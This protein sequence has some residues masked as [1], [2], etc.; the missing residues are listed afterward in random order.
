MTARKLQTEIDR[1]LKKVSE[2]VETFEEIFDK[3]TSTPN[4]N[5]KDK[6]E[7]DLK[8]EIKKLQRHRDQIKTWAASNEIKDKRALLENR[9]LIEQQMEK[10]K[11]CEKEMKTKTYSKE[12]LL[13][14]AE[15]DPREKEKQEMGEWISS[16]VDELARQMETTEAEVETLRGGSKKGKKDNAKAQRA[17]E[18]QE[19]IER[20][21]WHIGRLELILRLLENDQISTEQVAD[22]Q[23]N[24]K[25][26]VE[27][28]QEPDFEE[29]ELIYEELNLE[30]EEANYGLAASGIVNGHD[31]ESEDEV[32][33]STKNQKKEEEP[34]G[35]T[36]TTTSPTT[37]RS[38]LSKIQTSPVVPRKPALS[39][40]DA[41]SPS[42]A[43]SSITSP[44]YAKA[45]ASSITRGAPLT[46][47]A[48][49][50]A[51]SPP[52][53]YAKVAAAAA[54]AS[55]STPNEATPGL[56]SGSNS[57]AVANDSKGAK[58]I[59]GKPDTMTP[60]V[61]GVMSMKL[62]ED[63]TS[64]EVFPQS[65]QDTTKQSPENAS[66]QTAPDNTVA[67]GKLD[68]DADVD[69][70]DI[71]TALTNEDG[72]YLFPPAIRDLVSS[73]ESVREKVVTV[74]DDTVYAHQMLD[75]SFSNLPDATDSERPKRYT[76]RNP[77]PVPSYYPQQP[78]G[79][80]D[81]PAFYERFDV[82]VLF[83]IFYFQQGT[84]QQYLAARE[85]KRQSWRF[86][87][88]Y[89]TWFQRHEE[90]KLITDEYEQGTYIYFD[91][92]GAWCQRKKTEF[93]FEYRYLE[94]A[95]V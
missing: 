12:G 29:D 74:K 92:E 78:M 10:F 47:A 41:D 21:K 52:T 75:A 36:S 25:Y 19:R 2:G 88:K 45:A 70:I 34:S 89:L 38:N 22:I 18:L 63:K 46:P 68:E 53:G 56:V 95:D 39:S 84:Y 17:T 61:A 33:L 30:E 9:K 51:A 76:P 69:I 66:A 77:Y 27:Q 8:K 83:F 87:K 14:Q 59:I 11:A 5:Q 37:S 23:E 82:D 44:V 3:L 67:D 35:T 42:A 6:L 62:G 58:S 49:I 65:M 31:D 94:D 48:K 13:R 93:R 79:F 64:N 26:Y 40:A 16:M 57:D 60:L 32:P 1:L 90:P 85:L 80:L 43:K 54:A 24:V 20:Y 4:P 55:A 72:T 91:Y 50:P 71:K 15:L 73:F 86:H 7:A 28:N 81:N